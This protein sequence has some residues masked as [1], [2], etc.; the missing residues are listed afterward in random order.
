MP[1]VIA[2]IEHEGQRQAQIAISGKV[3]DGAGNPL[4]GLISGKILFSLDKGY[5]L[6]ADIKIEAEVSTGESLMTASLE[7]HLER[8]ARK[9]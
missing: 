9:K 3:H 7:A 2:P 6:L 4:A 5:L 1:L 8:T